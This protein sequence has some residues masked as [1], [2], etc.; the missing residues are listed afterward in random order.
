MAS[1]LPVAA[2]H[3]RA[4]PSDDA[5]TTRAP[6]GLK[7]ALRTESVWPAST[8]RSWFLSWEI[9]PAGMGDENTG[10]GN[11]PQEEFRT[12]ATIAHGLGVS[13]IR[14]RS[15]QKR[16]GLVG[17]I[18]LRGKG[19]WQPIELAWP[20]SR[21]MLRSSRNE[22]WFMGNTVVLGQEHACQ[23]ARWDGASALVT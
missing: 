7:A 21:G 8:W 9:V 16:R 14:A 20:T 5:V 10:H 6:S 1:A 13:S 2:S 15:G 23:R 12:L 17:N 4:V 18:I 22:M 3:S 11:R 19:S